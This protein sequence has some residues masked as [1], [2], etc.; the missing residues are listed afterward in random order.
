MPGRKM[1][2]GTK[3]PKIKQSVTKKITQQEVIND[4]L[5]AALKS[6]RYLVLVSYVSNGRTLVAQT[7]RAFALDRLPFVFDF[8][9]GQLSVGARAN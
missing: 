6:D 5:A 3:N 2:S 8:I 7:N 4:Q 1:V 9:T